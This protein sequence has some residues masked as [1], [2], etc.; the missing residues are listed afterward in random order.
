MGGRKECGGTRFLP[1]C[2]CEERM[3]GQASSL[4]AND[5]QDAR[6]T[7]AGS[8]ALR[9]KLLYGWRHR[10]CVGRGG[11]ACPPRK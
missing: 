6:P 2:H 4:S 9:Q 11:P 3:V 1:G 5:G 8:G 7:K 10:Q